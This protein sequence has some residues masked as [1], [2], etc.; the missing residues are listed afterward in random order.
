LAWLHAVP[1][2]KTAKKQ[3]E[4]SRLETYKA[5]NEDHSA[6]ELPELVGYEY[7]LEWLFEIGVSMHTGMGSVPLTWQEIE[8]WGKDFDLTPWEKKMLRE[9][10]TEYVSY[11]QKATDT[12]CPQPYFKYI[13]EDQRNA[14]SKNILSTLRNINK[15]KSGGLRKV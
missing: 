11:S 5:I 2:S 13:S 1:R 14:V 6:L 8:S 3:S 15:I 9:L 10:S 12:D 4:K 7:L